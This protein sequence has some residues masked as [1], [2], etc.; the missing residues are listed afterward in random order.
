MKVLVCGGRSY[1]DQVRVFQVLDELN[2]ISPISLII[3]G[4][5][6]GADRQAR[7]WALDKG[8]PPMTIHAAWR[9]YNRAA[10]HKRNTWML[11]FGQPD[12]CVAFP[13][14]IGTANMVEQANKSGIDVQEIEA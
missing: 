5:A 14:G 11:E 7:F 12:L 9:Y 3:E 1:T 4:G 6:E 2:K 13:G 8:V 10:G